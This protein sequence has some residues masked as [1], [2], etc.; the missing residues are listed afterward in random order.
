MDAPALPAVLQYGVLGVLT[1]VL[2][3]VHRH[4]ERSNDRWADVAIG[5]MKLMAE[6]K[7]KQDRIVSA[8]DRVEGRIVKMSEDT[9]V[10]RDVLK[11][12]AAYLAKLIRRVDRAEKGHE[13]HE[14]DAREVHVLLQDIHMAVVDRPTGQRHLTEIQ[15]EAAERAR[16]K[17]ERYSDDDITPTT[18]RTRG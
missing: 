8:Q 12:V 1:L 6:S 9:A 13:L 5:L 18:K 4:I 10:D 2:W 11:N 16:V 17:R 15:H 7:E 3:F 14:A